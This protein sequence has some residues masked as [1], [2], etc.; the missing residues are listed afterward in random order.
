MPVIKAWSWLF[1]AAYCEV[2]KF[3]RVRR[4]SPLVPLH[5][6]L[7]ALGNAG[8]MESYDDEIKISSVV[9]SVARSQDFDAE[10]RSRRGR[11]ERWR[12]VEDQFRRGSYP[13][14]IEV[15]RLGEVYFVADGHHR[16]AVARAL[17]WD[18]L[19]A[20]VRRYCTVAYARCCL[21]VADLA[22][23]AAERRFLE[24][25]PLPDEL[26]ADLRLDRPADWARLADA[27]MAWGYRQ[28]RDGTTYCCAHDLATA[29]WDADV[30]PLIA[31]LRQRGVA[32]DL[33]DI[34]A[35]VTAL[36]ERD[37][38]GI[39]DWDEDPVVTAGHCRR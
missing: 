5:D 17:G 25:V 24:Q 26:R 16:V 32:T 2:V 21:G 13:P 4:Q 8:V 37:R 9:G 30:S 38:L 36:A 18:S 7:N 29:W 14:P 39:L 20:H 33:P 11:D 23:K 1:G 6:A 34:Q 12:R 27:A 28:Q 22:G 35:Y 10:F 15:V 19:P 3:G 31:K